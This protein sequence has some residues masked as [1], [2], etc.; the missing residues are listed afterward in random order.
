M[1]LKLKDYVKR[2]DSK[3]KFWTFGEV[4]RLIHSFEE[5][6]LFKIKNR[7]IDLII[8]N[9]EKPENDSHGYLRFSFRQGSSN[10]E[11]IIYTD[12][13]SYLLNDNGKTVERF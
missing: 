7:G 5:T 11:Y 1:I 8:S 9:P 12:N 2:K 4:Q 10:C 13:E 6:S 3:Y